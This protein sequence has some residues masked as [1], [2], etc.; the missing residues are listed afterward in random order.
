MANE[1]VEAL[2]ILDGLIDVYLPDF[3]YYNDNLAYKYS[4]IKFLQ[5]SFFLYPN[6]I[7]IIIL[8]FF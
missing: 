7:F 1:N 6:F 4:N 2:K 3:K 8:P 5:L